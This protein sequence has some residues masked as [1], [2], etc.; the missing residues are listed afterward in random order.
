MR[1]FF[2]DA[3]QID[4]EAAVQPSFSLGVEKPRLT[5]LALQGTKARENLLSLQQLQN[6]VIYLNSV[7][8][9]V[10]SPVDKGEA[11]PCA[12]FRPCRCFLLAGAYEE[13]GR[14]MYNTCVRLMVFMTIV[15][16]LYA[17][18]Y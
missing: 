5:S 13:K 8:P 9:V 4:R 18:W 14:D 11:P 2:T 6:L 10:G 12:R 16:Q 3:Y 17:S 15:L 7:I 1:L